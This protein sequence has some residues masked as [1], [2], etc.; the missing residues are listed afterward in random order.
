MHRLLF[1]YDH[2]RHDEEEQLRFYKP[3]DLSKYGCHGL[4]FQVWRY[5]G[6][7]RYLISSFTTLIFA[8]ILHVVI[9]NQ[10][11]AS[12]TMQDNNYNY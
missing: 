2:C 7:S 6:E 10:M 3:R 9:V 4:Q 12:L 11:T 8:I 5:S 1:Q